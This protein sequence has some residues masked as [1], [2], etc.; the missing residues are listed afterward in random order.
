[1]NHVSPW[2]RLWGS[3]LYVAAKSCI[4]AAEVAKPENKASESGTLALLVDD[5]V[6]ARLSKHVVTLL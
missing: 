3:E 5:D 6:S 4:V 2:G 1:V